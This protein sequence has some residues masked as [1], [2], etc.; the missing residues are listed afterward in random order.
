LAGKL[1]DAG[2]R[3]RESHRTSTSDESDDDESDDDG[4]SDCSAACAELVAQVVLLPFSLP[5]VVLGSDRQVELWY[6]DYPY[7]N[8]AGYVGHRYEPLSGAELPMDSE[9]QNAPEP[10]KQRWAAQGRV[11]GGATFDGIGRAAALAR[12]LMPVP[13]ELEAS[14]LGF[15]EREGP[16]TDWAQ[17]SGLRINWRFAEA[18]TVQF[19]TSLGYQHWF[20]DSESGSD[21]PLTHDE[22]SRPGAELGYGF[23]AF[24]GK[25]FVLSAE[26]RIG[27][28]G[29]TYSWQARAT[30]G[31]MFGPVEW[32]AGYDEVNVGG[33]SLG[34]PI[35]GLRGF[36]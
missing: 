27:L 16:A 6:D 22:R 3:I 36:L 25:P 33:V 19:R 8:R 2:D 29:Q 4:E 5:R 30:L 1:D 13:I 28:L 21:E 31:A 18:R 24:V 14:W 9:L 12:V 17:L 35:A 26:G 10:G 15:A 34:S 23:D 20:E 11:E 7:A 32:Y